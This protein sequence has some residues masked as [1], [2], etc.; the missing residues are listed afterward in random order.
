MPFRLYSSRRDR[1]R[2]MS[3]PHFFQKR[4]SSLRKLLSLMDGKNGNHLETAD[5][6]EMGIATSQVDPVIFLGRKVN[7][8]FRSSLIF[9]TVFWQIR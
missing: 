7:L 3:F 6:V 8:L 9:H 4:P 5:Q 2:M 1:W